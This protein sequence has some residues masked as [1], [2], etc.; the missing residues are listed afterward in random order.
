VQNESN[1]ALEADYCDVQFPLSLNVVAGMTTAIVYGRIYEAGVT[2]AGG[3]NASVRAQL[4]YGP[5]TANPEYESSWSWT[6]AT[7]NAGFV[8]P[9]TDEYQATF[10]APGTGSYRYAYRFSLDYGVSWTLCDKNAGDSGAGSNA[11]VSFNFADL[12]VLTVP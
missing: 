5:E 8:D 10:T 12:P 11:G 7:Y 4:G 3:A 1:A 2:E 9:S 6:N